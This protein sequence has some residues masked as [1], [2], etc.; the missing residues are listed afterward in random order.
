MTKAELILLLATVIH[1]EAGPT[2]PDKWMVM[3]SIGNRYEAQSGEFGLG[4]YQAVIY[5]KAAYSFLWDNVPNKSKI[6]AQELSEWQQA[7]SVAT[8]YLAGDRLDP[9]PGVLWYNRVESGKKL[10][11]ASYICHGGTIDNHYWFYRCKK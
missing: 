5:K 7:V 2:L 10:A 4:T 6:S 9:A 1:N 8:D 3:N 11:N